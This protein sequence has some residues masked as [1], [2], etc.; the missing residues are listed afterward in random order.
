EHKKLLPEEEKN[1]DNYLFTI[2]DG[3]QE[4][5]MIWLV[6]KTR[7][8]GVIYDINIWEGVQGK[9][10]VKQAMREVEVIAKEIGLKMIGLHVFGHNN[11]ARHLYEQLGYVETNINMRKSL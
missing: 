5:G 8:T 4:I 10:Y 11:V 3:H 9:G 1:E 7:E 2:R 6:R